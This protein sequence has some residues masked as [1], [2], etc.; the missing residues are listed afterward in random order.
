MYSE[1]YG[2]AMVRSFSHKLVFHEDT[3]EPAQLFDLSEDPA[4]DRNLVEDPVARDVLDDLLET[5]VRS[6]LAGG[7][8]KA[9]PGVFERR[10]RDT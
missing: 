4:E 8:L 7:R 5:R 6:Y 3:L 10:R 9:G 2:F 1:K